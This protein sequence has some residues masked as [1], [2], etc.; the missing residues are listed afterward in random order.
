MLINLPNKK[1]ILLALQDIIDNENGTR[2]TSGARQLYTSMFSDEV[3]V[4][5]VFH[6][7]PF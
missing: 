2:E 7:S 5:T 3:Y 1:K 4:L 6:P